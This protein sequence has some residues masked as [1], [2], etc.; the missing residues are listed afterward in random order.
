MERNANGEA[1]WPHVARIWDQVTPPLRPSP[2][3]LRLYQA[4][5]DSWT[6]SV[7]V[8]VLLLGVTPEIYRLEWP[9][10][11]V[12][13]AVDRSRD[14]IEH[15]WPGAPEEARSEDWCSMTFPQDSFD[16][17]VCDGGL[18]LLRHPDE[19][20][21]LAQRL[22]E[23]L[24]SGGRCILRLFSAAGTSESIDDVMAAL[25]RHE[26][27]DLSSLKLRLWAA[28]QKSVTQ[29]VRPHDV[30]S[31]VNRY[32]NGDLGALADDHGWPLDNVL[33]LEQHRDSD[34]RY[35]LSG[36][37]EVES[38]FVDSTGAFKVREVCYSGDP[39]GPCCPTVVLD[40]V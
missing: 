24:A 33:A 11:T 2:A 26:V 12:W 27:P 40:R 23:I 18:A 4:A 36:P 1:H 7:P 34:A 14:M 6:G 16:I 39:L 13:T 31:I 38:L 20:G 28:M 10:D 30:W 25:T 17:A 15:V 32:A 5:I 19:Q 35:H 9:A 37:R 21:K 3:D 29:G 8:R 22:A